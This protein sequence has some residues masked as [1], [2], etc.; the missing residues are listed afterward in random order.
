MGTMS[1]YDTILPMH[2][3]ICAIACWA[4]IESCL[5]P[6]FVKCNLCGIISGMLKS[7]DLSFDLARKLVM[8]VAKRLVAGNVFN[9]AMLIESRFESR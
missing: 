7:D 8:S 3:E 2:P 1:T 4:E 9:A 6:S 5:V